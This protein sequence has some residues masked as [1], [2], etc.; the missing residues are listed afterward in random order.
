MPQRN[1]PVNTWVYQT[2]K[3][4]VP[5][6]ESNVLWEMACSLDYCDFYIFSSFSENGQTLNQAHRDDSKNK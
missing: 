2:Y 6:S 1:T 4:C 3:M 5:L